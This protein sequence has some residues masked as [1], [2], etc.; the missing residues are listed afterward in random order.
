[1]ASSARFATPPL[2]FS[3][4][5]EPVTPEGSGFRNRG[6][7]QTPGA[8]ASP[9]SSTIS[10]FST[11]VLEPSRSLYRS[12]PSAPPSALGTPARKVT[13]RADPAILTC[14]DPSDKELYDLWVPKS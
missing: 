13:I 6:T 9:T 11:R 8:D 3:A 10:N 5:R 14:F 12:I 1:M 7:T 4:N 2:S